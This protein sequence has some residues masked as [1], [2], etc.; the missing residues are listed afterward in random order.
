MQVL[1]EAYITQRNKIVFWEVETWQKL[2]LRRKAL[3]LRAG[4]TGLKAEYAK[5][6]WPTKASIVR[7][8]V[9]VV[10]ITTILGI[11]IGMI[12]QLIQFGLDKIIG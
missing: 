2:K 12:D 1:S 10:I 9:V 5:I 8:S 11:L 3:K 6:I 7:Q 4:W